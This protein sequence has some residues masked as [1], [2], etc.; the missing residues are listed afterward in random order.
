MELGAEMVGD[1][2]EEGTQ[3]A[4]RAM[5]KQEGPADLP[6]MFASAAE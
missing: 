4:D 6:S 5:V 1:S 2:V 3:L